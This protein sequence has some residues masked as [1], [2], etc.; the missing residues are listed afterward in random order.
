MPLIVSYHPTFAFFHSPF[1]WGDFAA[2]LDR[3]ARMIRGELRPAPEIRT[4]AQVRIAD[5]KRI[6]AEDWFSCD[7]ET[8]PEDNEPVIGKPGWSA[9]M[10]T[11]CKL[12]LIGFGTP[13]FAVSF[14]WRDRPDLHA[15]AKKMLASPHKIKV[16][17]NGHWFDRPVLKRHGIEVSD[18]VWDTRDAR[19]A[20]VTT[21]PLALDY[22]GSLYD[23]VRQWKLEKSFDKPIYN[24]TDCTVTARTKVGIEREPEWKEPRTQRLYQIHTDLSIIAAEMHRIGLH[25]HRRN[26]EYMQFTLEQE[27]REKEEAFLRLVNI[28]GMRCNPNDMRA[29]IYKKHRSDRVHRFDLPDPMDPKMYSDEEALGT[30]SVKE[31]ALLL[32]MVSGECPPELFPI[33]DAYWEAESAKKRRGFLQSDMLLRAIGKDGR[34]RV[35]WNSCGTDTMRFSCNEPN[36]MAIEQILRCVIAPAPGFCFVHADKSQL[37]LRV[38]EAVADDAALKAALDTGDVYSA[39]ARQ[40][41]GLPADMDVKKLKP[42]ARQ[43]CKIIHLAS[44]YA[45]GAPTIYAQALQQDRSMTY[46]KVRLLNNAFK[47]MYSAT[48]DYWYAELKRVHATGY[49]EGRLLQGRRVYPRPPPITEVANWPIQRTASEMMA[50]EMIEL[51]RKVKKIPR[52]NVAIILHDA[53]DV[54]CLEKD[55]ARVKEIMSDTMDREYTIDGRTRRFPVEFKIARSSEDG[56]WGDV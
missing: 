29:L 22:M 42:K 40:W 13:E 31:S 37:E 14:R 56:S 6:F 9:K 32:L 41:F 35:G 27:I 24:A 21:S 2:D 51:D 38:M 43:Q 47:R 25:F 12:N 53:F 19:R 3:Y 7:I 5:L 1:N 10:P 15:F 18:P 33:I 55:E 39:D 23:D 54:H 28:D 17:Q 49:S 4:D 50:C 44:N 20:V 16:F 26:W 30:I 8:F 46:D 11:R 36:I 45:A 52:A 48:V 34:L